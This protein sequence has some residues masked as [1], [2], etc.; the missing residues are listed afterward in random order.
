MT[1]LDPPTLPRSPGDDAPDTMARA[2]AAA[3]TEAG[4]IALEMSRRGVES[5]TKHNDSPVSEADMCKGGGPRITV[6]GRKGI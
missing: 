4:A 3:V 2:L 6:F 5:W 1:V